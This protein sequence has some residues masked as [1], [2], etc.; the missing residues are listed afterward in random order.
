[1][2][3][4]D[5]PTA[6]EEVPAYEAATDRPRL[7]LT[8]DILDFRTCQRKYGLYKVR[9][10]S[11]AS[12]TAEFV[13]TFAHRAMEEAWQLSQQTGD[14]PTQSAMVDVL[15]QVRTDL[16]DEGRS[17][18]SWPAVLHAGYQ[19][20]RMVAT[21]ADRSLF[22][23]IVDSERTFRRGK[24]EYVLEGVVDMVLR[25]DAGPVLWDFKSARDPRRALGD[26]EATARGQRASRRRLDDYR[27]QLRLYHFL[28][29][30][31][32][33]QQPAR[34]ELVFLGEL[35]RAA[36]DFGDYDSLEAAWTASDPEPV[37]SA[38][39][40]QC[41]ESA[42]SPTDPGLFYA[43]SNDPD[44]VAAAVSEFEETATAILSC[45]DAD[46]WSAPDVSDLP[47]KQT[48]DDCGFLD[49]CAPALSQRDDPT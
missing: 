14:P 8:S 35:G 36:I 19:V 38:Q 17:P 40:Q 44:E 24:S 29:E 20:L 46:S 3:P 31:V 41:R 30:S 18:H 2:N 5:L 4:L 21:M 23:A 42:A 33:D 1:M 22:A 27:L 6:A 15:E 43:V 32:L 13:G 11:G 26:G 25:D 12:P 39:W 34:C 37:G 10:F 7:S 47:S 9:G 49:S 48:C 45:R 28:C 16:L